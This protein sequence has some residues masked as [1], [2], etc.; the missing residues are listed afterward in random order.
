MHH[1]SYYA[2]LTEMMADE[3]NSFQR[4]RNDNINNICVLEGVGEGENYRK[5]SKTLFFLGSSMRN[6]ANF[7][8]RNC[9]VIWEAPIFEARN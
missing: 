6:L 7:I 9:V 2:I 4:R 8:V 3:L 5:L 1:D